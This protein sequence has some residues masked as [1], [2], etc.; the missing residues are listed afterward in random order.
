MQYFTLFVIYLNTFHKSISYNKVKKNP[1]APL[2][3]MNLINNTEHFN[4]IILLSNPHI[5]TFFFLH[6]LVSFNNKLCNKS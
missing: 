2:Y 6:W 1:Q 3:G 4:C 5:K